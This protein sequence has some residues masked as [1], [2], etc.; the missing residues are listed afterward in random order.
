MKSESQ[1]IFA[2][3]IAFSLFCTNVIS[4]PISLGLNNIV[5]LMLLCYGTFLVSLN[6]S[7]ALAMIYIFSK[8]L[9]TVCWK[10][11]P[12]KRPTFQQILS[13]LRRQ[14][15]PVGVKFKESIL[16]Q[17]Q[18]TTSLKAIC[19]LSHEILYNFASLLI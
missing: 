7:F 10:Y 9:F 5:E 6:F 3:F 15:K 8:E 13:A 4:C 17:S 14:E 18:K 1:L 12:S 2:S 16:L 19:S 11:D